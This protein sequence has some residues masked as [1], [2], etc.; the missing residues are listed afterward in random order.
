MNVFRLLFLVTCLAS[1]LLWAIVSV[2]PSV[3][4][5][6]TRESLALQLESEA[7]AV[8]VAESAAVRERALRATQVAMHPA[9]IDALSPAQPVM[10][11]DGAPLLA[12]RPTPQT[13]FGAASSAAAGRSEFLALFDADGALI[14]PT[15]PSGL[16]SPVELGAEG[17][18]ALALSSRAPQQEYF[19]FAGT[20]FST[21]IQ[22]VVSRDGALLGAVLV[23]DSYGT[24]TA[25]ARRGAGRS[26]VAFFVSRDIVGTSET[27]AD[28]AAL[29]SSLARRQT[30]LDLGSASGLRRVEYDEYVPDSSAGVMPT[31]FVA[32]APVRLAEGE[33]EF[34]AIVSVDAIRPPATLLAIL[35]ESQA[36]SD[37]TLVLW[38]FLAL[39]FVLF[40]V[41]LIIHDFSSDRA[42]GRLSAR[43]VEAVTNNDPPPILVGNLPA[44]LRPIGRA[45]N[46][47]LDAYRSQ[48]TGARRAREEAEQARDAAE[49]AREEAVASHNDAM[50]A[51]VDVESRV[52]EAEARVRAETSQIGGQPLEA[53]VTAAKQVLPAPI[54]TL[55]DDFSAPGTS[56]QIGRPVVQSGLQGVV[57]ADEEQ[58]ESLDDL[59]EAMEFAAAEDERDAIDPEAAAAMEEVVAHFNLEV[60]SFRSELRPTQLPEPEQATVPP[61][62][63]LP[64]PSLGVDDP[65]T[66]TTPASESSRVPHRGTQLLAA[67]GTMGSPQPGNSPVLARPTAPVSPQLPPLR[68]V[69]TDVASELES[70]ATSNALEAEPPSAPASTPSAGPTTGDESSVEAASP[71]APTQSGAVAT[72]PVKMRRTSAEFEV[73]ATGDLP[74]VPEPAQVVAPAPAAADEGPMN[75]GGVSGQF[76]GIFEEPEL[77]EM[78]GAPDSFP[79]QATAGTVPRASREDMARKAAEAQARQLAEANRPAPDALLAA[80]EERLKRLRSA[81]GTVQAIHA[82]QAGVTTIA[83][84]PRPDVKETIAGDSPDARELY[85][86]FIE[87]RR[88]CNESDDLPYD[89]FVRRLEK[90][91]T[92]LKAQLGCS[93]V[94][95]RVDSEAG[96]ATLKATPIR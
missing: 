7:R 59:A 92:S 13:A 40:V 96:K 74:A 21:S 31:M 75:R 46:L 80:A 17:G 67:V 30:S 34:G 19:S 84:A 69:A 51:R 64:A 20:L 47:F 82:Q 22:P 26:Q 53:S 35:I 58:A 24:S 52:A 60:P 25:V 6:S 48:L 23:G 9:L 73:V 91:R 87:M 11:P 62:S 2:A 94:K 15:G 49:R 8:L 41:G 78:L 44:T 4:E 16:V 38:V 57:S 88:H 10:G 93:D 29:A 63:V 39:G 1:S 76:A 54:A 45:F 71:E 77:D 81:T 3:Y 28:R 12:T 5:Q 85:A 32:S 37:S 33:S 72:A 95:F 61:T 90:N 89:R 70:L 43:I 68:A 14:A 42:V 27:A 18:L 55:P 36:F 66:P 65:A 50:S 86:E 83:P 79:D 56:P